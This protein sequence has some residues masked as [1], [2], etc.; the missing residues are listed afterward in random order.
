[1]DGDWA[2]GTD[3]NFM[4]EWLKPTATASMDPTKDFLL[5]KFALIG[6]LSQMPVYS[7]MLIKAYGLDQVLAL[8]ARLSVRM[9]LRPSAI[10]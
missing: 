6:D 10:V 1:M 7:A 2:E 3:A 5:Q 9:C 8:P 4:F